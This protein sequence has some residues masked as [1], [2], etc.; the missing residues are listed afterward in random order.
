MIPEN[1]RITTDH[2][3]IKQW[4]EEH[5]A[6]PAVV[7]HE[8]RGGGVGIIDID[9]AHFGEDEYVEPISW[10]DFFEQFDE[11]NLAFVY[12]KETLPGEKHWF[13]KFTKRNWRP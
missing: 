10:E 11:R 12:E 1:V 8:T 4:A 13:H 6:R 5:N 7:R 3:E 9:L 2:E